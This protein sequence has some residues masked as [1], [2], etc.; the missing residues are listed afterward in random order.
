MVPKG[1][2]SNKNSLFPI[3][4]LPTGF[5]FAIFMER[6]SNGNSLFPIHSLLPGVV[7]AQS[8][9]GVLFLAKSHSNWLGFQWGTDAENEIKWSAFNH[10]TK[11]CSHFYRT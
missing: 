3:D 10:S 7:A 11:I 2:N 5:V 1:M 6:S 9:K 8:L 4:N